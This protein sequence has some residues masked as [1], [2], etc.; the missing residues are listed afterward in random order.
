MFSSIFERFDRTY[1]VNLEARIDRKKEM[2]DQFRKLGMSIPSQGVRIFKAIAPT[3]KGTFPS[4]GALGNFTSQLEILKEA[5]ADELGS[6]L[7]LEDDA[8]FQPP[9]DAVLARM[10]TELRGM[11]WDILSL[12]YLKPPARESED[13]WIRWKSETTGTH[14]YAV[15]GPTIPRFAEFLEAC[16]TRPV[17]HPDGGPMHF[18][19]GFNLFRILNEDVRFFIASPCLATQ[20]SS[21][22]DIH[23][24]R[25]YDRIE[26]LKPIIGALRKLKTRLDANRPK[27]P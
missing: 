11:E 10:L 17:G 13:S 23:D 21:R 26:A 3:Q 7:I 14:F 1:V 12:G 20:R 16:K 19:G 2:V 6:V 15:N 18:D 27:L 22:T 8:L 25:F 4:L 24:L 5:A 9:A